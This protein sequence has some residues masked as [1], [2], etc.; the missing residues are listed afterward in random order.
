[1]ALVSHFIARDSVQ[2]SSHRVPIVLA[3]FSSF[4]VRHHSRVTCNH[5]TSAVELISDTSRRLSSR[6]GLAI[7]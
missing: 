3:S 2:R 5:S 4:A 1:M 7:S 6:A